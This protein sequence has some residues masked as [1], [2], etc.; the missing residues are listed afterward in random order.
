MKMIALLS[1]FTCHPCHCLLMKRCWGSCYDYLCKIRSSANKYKDKEERYAEE[2]IFSVWCVRF[3]AEIAHSMCPAFLRIQMSN[4]LILDSVQVR[5]WFWCCCCRW[6]LIGM[7]AVLFSNTKNS[8]GLCVSAKKYSECFCAEDRRVTDWQKIKAHQAERKVRIMLTTSS[9]FRIVV[10]RKFFPLQ[11]HLCF[12]AFH[13]F[14]KGREK[15]S[16]VSFRRLYFGEKDL[17]IFT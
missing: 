10:Q 5:C 2:R 9:S 1:L 17:S 13:L 8:W 3:R 12:L 14:F 4:V 15:K 11:S 7:Y 6:S 16:I